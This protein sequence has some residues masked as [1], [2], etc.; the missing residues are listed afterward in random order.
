[1]IVEYDKSFLKSLQKIKDT[2]IHV[3][4]ESSIISIENAVK[5]ESISNVKKLKGHKTII[6]LKLETI[7]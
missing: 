1:M 7:A 2:S 3:K 4:I 5:L 6:D